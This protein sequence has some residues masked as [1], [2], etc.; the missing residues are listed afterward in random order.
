MVKDKKIP[1]IPNQTRPKHNKD[2]KASTTL[3]SADAKGFGDFSPCRT[4]S[5]IML[6]E[7]EQIHNTSK[8]RTIIISDLKECTDGMGSKLMVNDNRNFIEW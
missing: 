6:Q 2:V 1:S 8:Q 5:S 3:T 7:K 4:I